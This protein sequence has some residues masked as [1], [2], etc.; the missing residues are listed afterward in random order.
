MI[1]FESRKIPKARSEELLIEHVGDEAVVYDLETK[2]AHCLNALAA[3]VFAHS[4]GRHTTSEIAQLAATQLGELVTET[5]IIAAVDELEAATLLEAPFV[6]LSDGDTPANGDG[7]S[8]RQMM[9][10][11][12]FA[13]AAATVAGGM[14]TSIAAPT[15]MAVACSAQPAGCNCDKTNPNGNLVHVNTLC[16]SGHCC[17]SGAK[18]VCNIGCCSPTNDGL[19]CQCTNGVCGTV[20]GGTGNP[21]PPSSLCCNGACTPNSG[22]ACR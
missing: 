8:R 4:D 10:K 12:A 16:L 1:L 5:Q 15:A 11:V 21:C 13:G 14:V 17:G 9:R 19:Q 2:E 20:C 6:V 18:D 7:L 3:T 22:T